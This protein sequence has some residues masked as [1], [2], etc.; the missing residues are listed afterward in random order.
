MVI[1]TPPIFLPNLYRY[2]LCPLSTPSPL[3]P[4]FLFSLCPN[5]AAHIHIDVESPIMETYLWTSYLT[6]KLKMTILQVPLTSNKSLSRG[7]SLLCPPFHDEVLTGFIL[8]RSS[9]GNHSIFWENVTKIMY[10]C[11]CQVFLEL[12]SL[13]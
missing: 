8:S 2:P 3:L 13:S 6:H 9:T 12:I 7:R 1:S 10:I 4:F 11:D 5:C